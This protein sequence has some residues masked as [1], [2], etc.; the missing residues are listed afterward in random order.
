M[1]AEQSQVWQTPAGA[2]L[3]A[4]LAEIDSAEGVQDFLTD[5]MT[6]KE[7]IEISSRLQAA[8]MLSQKRTYVEIAAATKLSSRTIA[9]ISTW[10]QN[11]TGGYQRALELIA[12][13]SHLSPARAE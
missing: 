7:L 4:V 1:K 12:H 6:E 11:G 5:V 2:Q 8:K 10:L 3:A 9:R 13:H